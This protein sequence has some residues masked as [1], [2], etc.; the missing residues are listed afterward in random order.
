MTAIFAVT[1]IASLKWLVSKWLISVDVPIR[2]I[3]IS[4][5]IPRARKVYQKGGRGGDFFGSLKEIRVFK[6]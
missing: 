3:E 1:H 5:G 2:V 6:G 4:I